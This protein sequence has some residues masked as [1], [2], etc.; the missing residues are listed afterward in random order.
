MPGLEGLGNLRGEALPEY[1]SCCYLSLY[2]HHQ[3]DVEISLQNL[4]RHL[5][6]P[7]LGKEPGGLGRALSGCGE[8]RCTISHLGTAGNKV[9]AASFTQVCTLAAAARV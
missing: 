3:G 4:P 9:M 6:L 7:H 2:H 8:S 1:L 5:H